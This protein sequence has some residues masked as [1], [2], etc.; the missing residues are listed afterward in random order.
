MAAVGAEEMKRAATERVAAIAGTV[1][2]TNDK[3]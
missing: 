2:E 3:E 1:Q